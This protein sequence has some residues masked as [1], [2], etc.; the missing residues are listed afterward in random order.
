[1]FYCCDLRSDCAIYG[2]ESPALKAPVDE[3]MADINLLSLLIS[4]T[5]YKL[6]IYLSRLVTVILYEKFT[7]LYLIM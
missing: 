6:S 1:M 7:I 4:Y 2:M 5:N 3:M